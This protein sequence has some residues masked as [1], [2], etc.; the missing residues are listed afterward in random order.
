MCYPVFL[1]NI[2]LLK[3]TAASWTSGEIQEKH[4]YFSNCMR[5][6]IKLKLTAAEISAITKTTNHIALEQT[7]ILLT[8]INYISG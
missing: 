3:L 7:I 1:S 4:N 2:L 6:T 8:N 5:Y